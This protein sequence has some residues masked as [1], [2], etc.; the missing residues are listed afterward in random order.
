MGEHETVALTHSQ[1]ARLMAICAM[2][3]DGDIGFFGADDADLSA[4]R[5]AIYDVGEE[6]ALQLHGIEG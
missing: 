2:L 5:E 6:C 4:A 1:A 3:K